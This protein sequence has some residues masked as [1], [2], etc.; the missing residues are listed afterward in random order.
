MRD[1]N[2]ILTKNT[3]SMHHHPTKTRENKYMIIDYLGGI[4]NF[5]DIWGHRYLFF[6]MKIRL[7]SV[8]SWTKIFSVGSEPQ[9]SDC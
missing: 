8:F 7:A 9:L 5:S 2:K 1:F 6:P 4:G 3:L